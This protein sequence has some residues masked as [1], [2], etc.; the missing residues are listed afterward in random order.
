MNK[1]DYKKISF[2]FQNNDFVDEIKE[3]YYIEPKT[4]QFERIITK[5]INSNPDKKDYKIC[6]AGIG[7]G[8]AMYNFYIETKQFDDKNFKFYGVEKYKEYVDFF[9]KNLKQY[10]NNNITIYID[11][12]MNHNYSEYDIVYC[13][14]PFKKEDDLIGMYQKI[15][16]ELKPNSILLEYVLYGNG[17]FNTI[18]KIHKNNQDKN[19]L[20]NL[21]GH[22]LLVIK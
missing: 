9:D 12:I 10:W 16:D 7:L 17:F 18:Q 15:V 21:N 19:N 3:W 11:D 13:Y 6:D 4:T 14:A 1:E 5:I 2:Q 22:N 20:I 8:T